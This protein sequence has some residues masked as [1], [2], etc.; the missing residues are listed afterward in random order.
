MVYLK[1]H[2]R[3]NKACFVCG[4]EMLNVHFRRK[5]CVPCSLTIKVN[6]GATQAHIAVHVEV[7]H[8][9]MLP[10]KSFACVDCGRPAREYDHRDYNKPLAVD[11]VCNCCNGKRGAA[12]NK[13]PEL[14]ITTKTAR[15]RVVSGLPVITTT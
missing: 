3:V 15:Q 13:R 10:A 9:R 8:G 5:Y 6:S 4:I 14:V 1:Q 11:P 7:R 12:I 2:C